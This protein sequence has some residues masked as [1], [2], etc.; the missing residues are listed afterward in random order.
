[1]YGWG[2]GLGVPSAARR[3]D[4][5]GAADG[6][7]EGADAG[8]LG[9]AGRGRGAGAGKRSG[10]G[11]G[12]GGGSPVA[13]PCRGNFTLSPA[14]A[15]VRLL[16]LS[17]DPSRYSP[18]EAWALEWRGATALAPGLWKLRRGDENSCL[19]G[20]REL[21]E[22]LLRRTSLQG[23][24]S[25][26]AELREVPPQ[27]GLQYISVAPRL[28]APLH[29]YEPRVHG[30]TTSGSDILC[31]VAAAMPSPPSLRPSERLILL[32]TPRLW[33]LTRRLEG[34]RALAAQRSGAYDAWRVRPYSFSAATDLQLARLAVSRACAQHFRS[35]GSLDG[36]AMLD[37]CCGSGTLLFAALLSGLNAVGFDINPKAIDGAAENLDYIADCDAVRSFSAAD[38]IG[39]GVEVS[40]VNGQRASGHGIGSEVQ[41]LWHGQQSVHM[42][43]RLTACVVQLDCTQG[44]PPD[45]AIQSVRIVV[46]SLPWGRN[47]RIPHANYL[48]LLLQP[49]ALALPTATFCLISARPFEADILEE[50]GLRLHRSQG[51]GARCTVSILSPLGKEQHAD[52]NPEHTEEGIRDALASSEP[53][54]FME[55]AVEVIVGGGLRCSKDT[56]PRPPSEGEMIEIQC[57]RASGGRAWLLAQVICIDHAAHE[58]S[59]RGSGQQFSC[60]L[61]WLDTGGKDN[62]YLVGLPEEIVL[63]LFVGPNWR[64]FE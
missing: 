16:S 57:R 40:R 13:R 15:M 62:P 41:P 28:A 49:L 44:P 19:D 5:H 47:Q 61:L 18:L 9:R 7:A 48:N 42:N 45:E 29:D 63:G 53:I 10:R 39:S 2:R 32:R 20:S 51:L 37:P 33:Y 1:M 14:R 64:F 26:A 4:A 58:P 55:E 34:F 36:G 8:T 24:L 30:G 12:G 6:R 31:A 17:A 50:I 38:P 46:A 27:W 59:E 21:L 22:P 54:A 43:G 11:R 25:A 3:S 52:H 35:G 23:L 56:M 60:R